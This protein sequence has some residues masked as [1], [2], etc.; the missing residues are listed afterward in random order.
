MKFLFVLCL[1]PSWTLAQPAK[2]LI[3][4]S[5]Q[6]LDKAPYY[7]VMVM[8]NDGRATYDFIAPDKLRYQASLEDGQGDNSEGVAIQIGTEYW[9]KFMDGP[10]T[11]S[12]LDTDALEDIDF[13]GEETSNVV[14]LDSLH[15]RFYV[16][17]R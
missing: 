11:H 1:L 3:E 17:A 8:S 12:T 2:Q 6:L 10:W 16:F 5:L 15:L 14:L 4:K 9:D 7:S 13:F